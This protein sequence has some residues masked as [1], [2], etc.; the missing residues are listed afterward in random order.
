MDE[1]FQL[2]LEFFGIAD[3]A[4]GIWQIIS[5]GLEGLEGIGALLSFAQGFG[6]NLALIQSD[7][8][9]GATVSP[10]NDNNNFV[11]SQST[12]I[13]L[14]DPT[15]EDRIDRNLN[16]VTIVESNRVAALVCA[17]E[18]AGNADYQTVEQIQAIRTDIEDVFVEMMQVDAQSVTSVLSTPEVRAAMNDLRIKTLAVLDQKAQSAWLTSQIVRT[19]ALTAPSLTYLLY[20]E[21]ITTDID[22]RTSQV[23]QLNQQVSAVAMSG[24]LTVLRGFNA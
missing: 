23:R 15:T 6:N 24:E 21:S 8:D 20:A 1:P 7:L 12:N 4:P 9:S 16:R 19:G 11:D 13:S 22:V 10:V 14:W 17:Y 5:E 3:D 2:A 18:Q